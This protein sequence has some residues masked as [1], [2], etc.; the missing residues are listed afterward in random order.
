MLFRSKMKLVLTEDDRHIV[1]GISNNEDQ[2]RGNQTIGSSIRSSISF[3]SIAQALA[4]D[5]FSIYYVDTVTDKFIEFSAHDDYN[6]LGIEKEGDDFFDTS[7]R[8]I[9]KVIHPD[10]QSMMLTAFTKENVLDE[11]MKEGTFTLD[12]RIMFNGEPIYVS[13]KATHMAESDN[14]H[15]VIGVNSID[16][17]VRRQ[18]EYDAEKANTYANNIIFTNRNGGIGYQI[19]TLPEGQG[20]FNL[21]GT[22]NSSAKLGYSDGDYYYTPDNWSDEMFSNKTRQGYN[23]SISAST[24]RLNYYA[25]IGYLNDQGVISG[26]G[27]ER[28]SGRLRAE[29]KVFD[30]LRIGG[31]MAYSYSNSRYPGEQTSTSSSG[32]AFFIA[33]MIAPVY[34][35]YVRDAQGNIMYNKKY[36]K[37]IYDYG[38]GNSTHGNRA[39]MSIAN[40]AGD[41]VYNKTEYLMDIM[42]LNWFAELTPVKGLTLTARYG[43]TTDNTRYNDLGNALYGQSA[44]YGGTAYQEASRTYGF[45]QQYVANYHFNLQEKHDID[46]TAGYEGYEYES[47][48]VDASGQNL[49]NPDSYYINNTIDQNR[50]YGSRSRY[51][52]EGFFGRANYSYDEKYIGSGSYRRD[53]SSRFRK[54][55]RWF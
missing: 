50:G 19:Y 41:L 23:A 5:Y 35:I 36:N 15:L 42:N 43:L 1:I 4:A 48:Y 16:S 54:D 14:D 13:M 21:D 30:W 7:R 29:Y 22:M 2:I 17:Q 20:L 37:P 12:Y 39:F 10:D 47:T 25:S 55:N 9:L 8:N 52:T 34:P 53:A 32:N 28:Y 38:D 11:V 40:P 33:N 18:Q 26:S 31:N 24:D 3:S 51:A 27:F 46:L 49:Y 6:S 44:S 45:T